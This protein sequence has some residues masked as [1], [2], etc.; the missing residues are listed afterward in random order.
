MSGFVGSAVGIL[1]IGENFDVF[2]KLGFIYWDA[3][4]SGNARDDTAV[5]RALDVGVVES[6]LRL[7]LELGLA[8]PDRQHRTHT[9]AQVLGHEL[10]AARLQV[11]G[12]DEAADS[13]RERVAKSLLVG[14]TVF[15]R[16]AVDVH[17][18]RVSAFRLQEKLVRRLFGEFYHLVLD[19]RTVA[20]AD[21]FDHT[22]E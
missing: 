5:D 18:A 10:Q 16:D 4:G 15:G 7:P 17:F 12:V 11:V 8:H 1:P 22:C 19:A 13:F 2:A 6:A 21:A 9:F 20:R 3:D 14:T